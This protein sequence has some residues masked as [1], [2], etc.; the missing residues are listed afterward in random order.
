MRYDRIHRTLN[1]KQTVQ[2][3]DRV[4]HETQC[5]NHTKREQEKR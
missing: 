1:T 2:A 5:W 4:R 3:E